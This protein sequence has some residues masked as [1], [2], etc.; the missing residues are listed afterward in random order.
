MVAIFCKHIG[1]LNLFNKQ[2]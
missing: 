1:Q 2:R